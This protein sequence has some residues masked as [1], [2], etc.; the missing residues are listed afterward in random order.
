M[1]I[2][3]AYLEISKTIRVSGPLEEVLSLRIIANGIKLYPLKK[4]LIMKS[5]LNPN[6]L[7]GFIMLA[8]S[9]ATLSLFGQSL[10]RIEA[11][12]TNPQYDR[13]TRTYYLDVELNSKDS[14]EIL[15]GMNLRFFYD[16]S[17]M[18]F[19]KVDQFHQGYGILGAQPKPAVGNNQSGTQLFGF[20]H[21]AAYIN[22]ALQLRDERFPLQI[23]TNAWVKAFRLSFKVPVTAL[24]K[25]T[26]CPSV[27]WDREANAGAGGF[28]PGSAGLVITVAETNRATRYVSGPTTTSAVQF[29]WTYG[30]PGSLPHGNVVAGDCIPIGDVVYMEEQEKT[31]LKGYSLFQN[32]PNPF[33]ESTRIDFIL[34]SAQHGTIYFFDVDGDVKEVIE[35]DFVSGRNQLVLKQKPWMTETSVIYYKLQTDKYTSKTFT[36]SLVRA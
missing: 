21:G 32:Q 6:T 17:L 9:V 2:S 20:S 11:R 8:L 33:Y 36:M 12:F 5:T 22:G 34:P 23:S 30:T 14:P 16:A 18:Q 24:N 10:P 35:G 3:P 26:F 15:F 29:N 1:V 4:S 13:Q 28:L 25:A 19:Q 27:I 31:D 7:K